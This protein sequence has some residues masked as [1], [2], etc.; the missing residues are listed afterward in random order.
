MEGGRREEKKNP[1]ARSQEPGAQRGQGRDHNEKEPPP[2]PSKA[3]LHY[4]Q[5]ICI[6]M[7][8]TSRCKEQGQQRERVHGQTGARCRATLFVEPT[9]P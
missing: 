7:E 4:K 5:Q 1:G 9:K 8:K 2:P 3:T 6:C